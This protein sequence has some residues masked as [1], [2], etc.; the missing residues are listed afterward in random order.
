[1]IEMSSERNRR[2]KRVELPVG[3]EEAGTRLDIFLT[4]RLDNLS[5]SRIKRMIEEGGI[6]VAGTAVKPGRRLAAGDVVSVDLLALKDERPG[7]EL[8]PLDILY[9][10]DSIAVVN[11]PPGML[12]HPLLSLIHI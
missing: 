5:R 8:I 2:D 4:G 11:K 12:V 6:L 9:R 3:P 1:M 10:D 7:P